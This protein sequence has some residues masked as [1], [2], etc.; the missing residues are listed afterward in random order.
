MLTS[1]VLWD[2][3]N[4]EMDV[5]RGPCRLARWKDIPAGWGIERFLGTVS[6][7]VVTLEDVRRHA[8]EVEGK[9]FA[10]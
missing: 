9:L 7:G 8:T 10:E 2:E 1:Y 3:K 5:F 6:Q 4:R